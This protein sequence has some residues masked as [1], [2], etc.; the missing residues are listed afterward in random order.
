MICI[1]TYIYIYLLHRCFDWE[2]ILCVRY[3]QI[4]VSEEEY[5]NWI[6]DAE[7]DDAQTLMPSFFAALQQIY[8]QNYESA[9]TVIAYLLGCPPPQ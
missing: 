4:S 8:A 3:C 6:P 7:K 1:Y 9:V 5:L 2:V